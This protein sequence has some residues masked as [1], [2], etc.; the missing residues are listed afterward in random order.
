MNINIKKE[1]YTQLKT[2]S[3]ITENMRVTPFRVT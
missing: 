3:K 1:R 2:T